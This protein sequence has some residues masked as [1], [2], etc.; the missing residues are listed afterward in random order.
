[1]L[2][3]ANARVTSFEWRTPIA[4]VD[5]HFMVPA[6]GVNRVSAAAFFDIGGAWDAGNRP[7]RYHRGVGIEMLSE[8]K[9]L[10]TMGLQVRLG[11]AQGLDEPK[12]TRG[13]FAV[14][15]AF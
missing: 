15:R 11:V 3:G 12:G 9:F 8:V 4:D 2:Q 6:V 7:L 14:G 1:V 10:Y 5:R 13:Y